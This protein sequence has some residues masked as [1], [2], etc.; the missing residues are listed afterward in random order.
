MLLTQTT[1]PFGTNPIQNT[2]VRLLLLGLSKV[3]HVL[4]VFPELFLQSEILSE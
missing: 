3:L 4:G 2:E 1:S